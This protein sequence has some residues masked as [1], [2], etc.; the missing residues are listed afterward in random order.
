[1]KIHKLLYIGFSVFC[2]IG[3]KNKTIQNADIRLLAEKDF[4]TTVNNKKVGI[5]TLDSG[6]GI[7]MQVTNL[8][9]RIVSLWTPDR[10]NKYE[11]IVLGY[12]NIEEYIKNP[13]SRFLG[14]VLGR[15][16]N[17]I[18]NGKFE[19]DGVK[20]Q[21]PQNS[22]TNCLHG[23]TS[24]FDVVVWNVDSVSNNEI[25]LSYFSPDGDNGFPGNLNVKMVYTLTPENE[26]KIKYT[27][28]TDKSTHV[29]LSNHSY[30]NLKGEG[31]GTIL[32]HELTINADSIT[33]INEFSIP[34]G[35]Y[36][37]VE[38]TPF[39]FRTSSVIGKRINE[40]NE[41]LKNGAG[42]DHNWVLNRK[43]ESDVEW[44]VTL[45]EPI[46]GRQMQIWTDQP[47]I[48]IYTSNFAKGTDIGKYNKPHNYRE[49]IALETQ[50]FP[51]SPNQPHFP[52]TR[53]EPGQVYIQN[54]IYK[55]STN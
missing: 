17:R 44:A 37:A 6:N 24:G 41:Q 51:D 33:P 14:S 23:G 12:N 46:S 4:S 21:L 16:A 32:D 20:Y 18:A 15:Y 11:D 1:M 45:Y 27:A 53:L 9:G 34:T 2:L 54:T 35:E 48:Q 29:N 26:F 40:I 19:I 38:N 43:T 8:G 13:N 39:D 47:G 31:N 25:H 50:K 36:L 28:T 7:I 49:S 30:F 10:N 42:Y 3:C 5:Y 22:G 55:F 52:S